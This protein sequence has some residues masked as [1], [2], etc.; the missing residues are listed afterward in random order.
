MADR[1][2]N[3][4]KNE[5]ESLKFRKKTG[6][7][8]YMKTINVLEKNNAEFEKNNILL[9]GKID[10]FNSELDLKSQEI[11]SHE[12]KL[13]QKISDLRLENQSLLDDISI[14]SDN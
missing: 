4:L 14:L 5:L 13:H 1:K 2:I 10:L 8:E 9:S 3:I 6:D 7:S 12:K 11:K